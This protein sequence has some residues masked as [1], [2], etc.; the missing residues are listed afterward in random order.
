MGN[1]SFGENHDVVMW[2][3]LLFISSEVMTG[4]GA[5]KKSKK[6]K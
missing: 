6:K 4:M 3:A 5:A 2:I 1:A